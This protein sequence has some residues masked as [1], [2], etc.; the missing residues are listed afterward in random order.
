MTETDELLVELAAAELGVEDGGGVDE[1]GGFLE[2]A[3]VV[4]GQGQGVP[5]VEPGE[6]AGGVVLEPQALDVDVERVDL[7]P[8]V[9][10]AQVAEEPVAGVAP[11]RASRPRASGGRR[12]SSPMNSRA[13]VSRIFSSLS[14]SGVNFWSIVRSGSTMQLEDQPESPLPQVGLGGRGALVEEPDRVERGRRRS[15]GTSQSRWVWASR[16]AST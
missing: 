3:G 11:G 10:V 12:G 15:V 9:G 4:I 8:A 7:E 1:L 16:S 14:C 13:R 5:G 6:R 2:L